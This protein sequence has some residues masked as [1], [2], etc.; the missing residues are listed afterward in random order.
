M[1]IDPLDM[2]GE[3]HER[4]ASRRAT[5]IAERERAT[6]QWLKADRAALQQIAQLEQQLADARA[7]RDLAERQQAERD[8]A[9]AGA[10]GELSK[11][12]PEPQ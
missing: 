9:Y 3:L 1:D 12:M 10:I 2:L 4:I 8:M 7:A 11:L 6:T 5:L